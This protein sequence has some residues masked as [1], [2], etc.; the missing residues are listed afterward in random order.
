M[1]SQ[2]PDD[3]VIRLW[4]AQ[5]DGGPVMVSDI[6]AKAAKFESGIRWRNLLE[7]GAAVVVVTGYA[8][9]LWTSPNVLARAGAFLIILAT[10]Y[11]V[12]RIYVRGSVSTMP[13]NM[14]L[15]TCLDFHRAQ[16]LR[17][18]DLLRS[19]WTWYLLPFVPGLLVLLIGRAAADPGRAPRVA[20][21]AIVCVMVF[22]GIGRLNERAAR[23]LDREIE[24]LDSAR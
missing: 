21:S 11:V 12:Y 3:D 16:L 9:I 13:G 20:I 22:L 15:T 4:Q 1:A 2:P 6:R 24:A 8:R 19:I 7:Y 10:L 23:R 18:R 5:T 17:Q 14:A